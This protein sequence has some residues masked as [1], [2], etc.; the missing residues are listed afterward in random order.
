M[1]Q[2]AP[3]IHREVLANGVRLL[4][5]PMP[6]VRSA[7]LG[8]WLARGSRH[9]PEA[10]AGIAHFVEHMLFKGSA[11]RTAEDIAQ[12][13][14]SIGGQMDAFT[15]KEY[16]G[17]YFKVLDAHL[18][19]AL[20]VLADLV[21]HPAFRPEDIAREQKVVVEEIKMVDDTP[22][23]LVHE[24]FAAQFWEAHALGRPILGSKASVDAL[25]AAAL[26][27]YFASAYVAPHLVVAAAG[28]VDPTEIRAL[29]EARFGALPAV[30]ESLAAA[31][32]RIVPHVL[33]HQ[34]DLEQ[35]HVC[36]GVE[37]FAYDHPD[38]HASYVLNTLLGGAMSSRLFQTI[39]ERHGLA[40]AVY[41]GFTAYRDSG[42]FTVYAGCAN[43]A[44]R[45]VVSLVAD[46]LRRLVRE[47]VAHEELQRAK[48]HMLGSVVLGLEGTSSRMTHIARQEIYGEHALGYDEALAGIAAVTQEDLQR[49]ATDLFG[50][51]RLSA[52]VLGDVDGLTLG[53]SELALQ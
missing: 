17:Y 13:I 38:R 12:A 26:H 25:T 28:H 50:R 7:S 27:D 51:G 10:H 24:L 22:D 44:V 21:L 34:K 23:D 6:H 29:V 30:V 42:S 9:E 48:D 16:A 14:D 40:Y 4:T 41:S 20:D 53:D 5:E 31:P 15:S 36:L 47:P 52:T 33:V 37:A 2:S 43:D 19:R 8:V 18:P 35:G 11:T 49:V 46:E 32:P 3:S 45:D 1:T 39:R